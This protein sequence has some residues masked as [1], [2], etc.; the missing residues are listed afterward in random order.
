M[1]ESNNLDTIEIKMSDICNYQVHDDIAVITMSNAPVNALGHKLRLGLNDSINKAIAD[2]K[3]KAIIITSA[4][5]HIFCGG[6]D[7]TEFSGG[8][9]TK[10]PFL[11]DVC[12]DTIEGSPKLIIAAIEGGAFGGGFEITLACDY[13]FAG[14]KAKC[15]LPEVLLGIIPG[16]GGTQRLPRLIPVEKA[17]TKIVSGSPTP[18]TKLHEMGAIDKIANGDQDFITEALAYTKS[19]IESD[20][21]KRSCEDIVIDQ[22]SLPDD[23]FETFKAKIAPKSRGF[24]APFK[25]IEAVQAAVSLP[26]RDGLQ[27]EQ[28]L[29][30]EAASTPQARAQQHLF[31]AERVASK[32]PGI[33]K[34]VQPRPIEKVGVI[35][36]GTMGAG[37]ALA[38][39][40]SG[41]P[42]TLLDMSQEGVDRGLG[43]I[44]KTIDRNVDKGRISQAQAD[45][46]FA[47]VQGSTDYQSL[48]DADL[49]IEAVFEKMEV[50]LDVF[51]KLDKICKPG[52]ILATN[53]ST[54]DINKIA[55]GTSRPQDVVGLHF[56]SPANIMRLL[57]IV[58]ADA[59]AD[60]VL[61]SSLKFAKAIRKVSV[62]AGVCF[63]FIGNRMIAEY[64]RE[65]ERL[66]LEG[67][68][69]AQVDKV[70]YD[71]GMAMGPLSVND[72]SGNDIPVYSRQ[73]YS[74]TSYDLD[75]S[76]FA[77]QDKLVEMGRL[78]QKTGSGFYQYEGRKPIEDPAV[79]ELAEEMAA[80][81]N[82]ER[83]KISDEEILERCLFTLIN[84]GAKLLEEQ[85]A[86]R[87][88]DIDIVYCNGYGFPTHRGGPMQYADEIGLDNVVNALQKYRDGLGSWGQTFYQVAPLLEKLVSQNKTLSSYTHSS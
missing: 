12:Y 64:A 82:I 9:D 19:L 75:P 70:M 46:Q 22:A 16:A 1:H 4:F 62:V 29:F 26:Y 5:S 48:A 71:Y 54:L 24:V 57:E 2:D 50:K 85:I 28:D 41:I 3:V 6:A 66:V 10:D 53:T 51:G 23:F 47:L 34:S 52:A 80:K 18:A 42:V 49:V 31:F 87:S 61:V 59:T 13:R 15:G 44:R 56:F 35:G 36:A 65:A 63:G 25:A 45:A 32:I 72:L 40:S 21:P 7:I 86:Y 38:I 27:K 17:L 68:S 79:I 39:I 8:D 77:V 60:D 55:A 58:R 84:E 67:A 20:A 14:A 30:L 83:R 73:E 76:C 74:A 11:P 78:G 88:S 69:P 81:H 33:D 37:I 43:H